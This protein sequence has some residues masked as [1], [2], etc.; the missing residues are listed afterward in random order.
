MDIMSRIE[1]QFDSLSKGHKQI[2][3]YII[4]NFDKAAFLNVSQFSDVV[5]VSEATVVRFAAELG[6]D[7]FQ[8]MQK[9]IQEYAKTKLTSLQRMNITYDRLGEGDVLKNVLNSDIDKI[10]STLSSIDNSDFDTVVN[11]IAG[12]NRIYI[13]GVRS[14][15]SLANFLGFYLNM[16]FDHVK[17][18]DTTS[19][20]EIFEQIFRITAGDVIIG[21]SFP[22]YS[23]RTVKALQYAKNAGATVI[24]ITDAETSPI[25]ECS[26][27]SLL[28][29]SDMASFV[30]SLVAPM[31][32]INALIVALGGIKKDEVYQNFE[33]LEN[34]WKEYHVYDNEED[35]KSIYG[36]E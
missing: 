28:A 32:V 16:M 36:V 20:S 26:S 33:R 9:A 13:L 4:G 6:Y 18:V 8:S 15:A 25:R 17:I 31:S 1:Q 29:R 27:Y 7:K 12:A 22:R 23:R 2:A 11:K 35:E 24:G 30:D 14:S 34:I 3:G 5:G 10:K 21:I 19:A